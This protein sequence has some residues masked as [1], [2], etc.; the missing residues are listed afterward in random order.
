[1]NKPTPNLSRV[2]SVEECRSTLV[3]FGARDLTAASVAKALGVIAKT[4]SSLSDHITMQ[5]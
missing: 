3:Q 2:R 4:P 1:M 5:V